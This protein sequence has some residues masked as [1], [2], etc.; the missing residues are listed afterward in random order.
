VTRHLTHRT[1]QALAWLHHR[2][3]E[4]GRTPDAGSHAVEYAVG[5]FI[6]LATMALVYAAY[7]TGL[8]HIIATWATD[9]TGT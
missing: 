4:L 9:L 6:G 1:T 5:I 7:K 3:T 8:T 2:S